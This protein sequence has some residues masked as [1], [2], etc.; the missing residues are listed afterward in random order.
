GDPD[1]DVILLYLE[2]FGNPRK[3]ARI[4]RRISRTKPIVAVKSG[5]SV[6]GTRAAG[7]HTAAAAT[8]EMAV[9]AL[10]RQ[11][12]VIRVDT[13]EELF[14][15]AQVLASQPLPP[16]PRVAIVGNSGGPGILAAD[17]CEA[18]GLQVPELSTVTQEP[19][20]GFLPVGAAV[21]NPVDL[22]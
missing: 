2:S 17:A 16:G 15:V 19:L 20:S 9:D 6:A 10:F 14:D 22:I 8:P 4:A 5:R 1:T 13:L 7:S 21:R 3:F 12:G 11:A 18:V